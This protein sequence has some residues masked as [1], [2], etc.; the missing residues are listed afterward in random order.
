MFENDTDENLL[1]WCVGVRPTA[2]IAPSDMFTSS[3]AVDAHCWKRL[4]IGVLSMKELL[5]ILVPRTI[6]GLTC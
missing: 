2:R 3:D 1:D 6:L 4:Q 5:D